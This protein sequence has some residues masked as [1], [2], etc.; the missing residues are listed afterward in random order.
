[1]KPSS[2]RGS[3]ARRFALA[4]ACGIVALGIGAPA[5]A[6]GIERGAVPTAAV[7]TAAMPARSL[8]TAPVA[9]PFAVPS[10]RS[11]TTPLAPRPDVPVVGA[12]EAVPA[13]PEAVRMSPGEQVVRTFVEACVDHGGEVAPAVDWALNHGFEP[14]DPEGRDGSDGY[15]LLGGRPGV[16]FAT[17]DAATRVLLAVTQDNNCTVWA[18]R[19]AGTSTQDAFVQ[20]A[21]A[22]A[23]RGAQVRRETDRMLERAGAWRR[24]LEYRL[25]LAPGNRDYR[26]GAVTTM[27]ESPAAQALRLAP[28]MPSPSQAQAPAPSPSAAQA[29]PTVR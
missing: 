1:M 10:V 12:E 23:A 24:Q 21:E 26:L 8:E 19:A 18:E 4:G 22:L 3:R 29:V 7:P 14:L 15:A 25:S 16:V 27:T 17:P 13:E 11:E 20:A 5:L 2:H 28:V 6:Q 9:T